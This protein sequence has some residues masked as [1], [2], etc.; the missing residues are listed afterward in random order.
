MAP[1]PSLLHTQISWL[2]ERFD[3]KAI[4]LPSGEYTGT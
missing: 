4:R 2:P 3:A 1:E